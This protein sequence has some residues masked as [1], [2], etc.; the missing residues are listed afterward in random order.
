MLYPILR[1]LLFQLPPE[2]AHKT[3]LKTLALLQKLGLSHLISRKHQQPITLM[4]LQF[5]NPIGLAAGF[6]KNGDYIDALAPLGF[7]FIEIGT[8]TP[9]PQPGNPKPRLFRLPKAQALINRMG[10]NNQGVDYLVNQ[11]KQ[12]K[13]SG[14]L[15]INIGKNFDT[16][17]EQ[18]AQD[19]L[20]CL[21]RVYAHAS[22]ITVN[23]S[24][25]NTQGLRQ[26]QDTNAL[27]ELLTA[28]KTAQHHLAE[29]HQKYVPLVVKIAPDLD[30]A[31]IEDM[32]TV[33]LQQKID[34]VIATNTT[35]SREGV[36]ELPHANE[37][38]GLSGKPLFDKSL[39]VVQQ[40]S[41]HLQGQI[42]IIGCGGIMSVKDIQTMRAA[43]ASLVQ[44][45]TGL[46]YQGLQLL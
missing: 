15:G 42:P 34:G 1:S 30:N 5:P 13:Y 29:Q 33:F 41:H 14:I 28:L 6:D 25:P 27:T 40:L 22:Y 31:A 8:I 45:Y 23:I 16:P 26:L 11:V 4:G 20:F 46:V 17:L 35:L 21:E 9:R 10:F 7:G 44:V 18:A 2:T 39:N 24:S 38:G 36:T 19:Y 32:A 43:G 12:A 3:T 37:T